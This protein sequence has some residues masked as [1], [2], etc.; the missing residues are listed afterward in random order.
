[1]VKNKKEKKAEPKPE[2]VAQPEPE[3]QPA[4]PEPEVVGDRHET[5]SKEDTTG[6]DLVLHDSGQLGRWVDGN[7]VPLR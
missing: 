5:L 3:P 4:A 6:D 7:F 1:M 2:P